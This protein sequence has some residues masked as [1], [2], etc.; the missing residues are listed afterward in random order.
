MD[1]N[2]ISRL[3]DSYSPINESTINNESSDITPLSLNNGVYTDK[4]L[5]D[6]FWNWHKILFHNQDKV[7]EMT[8]KANKVY[9]KMLNYTTDIGNRINKLSTSAKGAALADRSN[10]K[11][12]KIVYYTPTN[13]SYNPEDTTASV[14]NGKIFGVNNS[15]KFDSDKDISNS[16]ITL[17]HIR[18]TM[19]DITG[20]NDCLIRSHDN[21]P[22]M[23][24]DEIIN[25]MKRFNVTGTSS[26]S[27]SKTIEFVVDRAEYN[28]F[29]NIQIKTEK[30]YVYTVY[31]SVDGVYYNPLNS[32]KILTNELDL[33]FNLSN[34]RYIKISVHFSRHTLLNNGLYNYIWDVNHIFIAMK[35][36]K[37]ETVFQSN[38]IDINAAGEYIAIDT[39]DNYENKNVSINY[40]ISIDGGIFKTIKPLRA[41]SRSDYTIRSLI[42]INDFIDNNVGVMTKF[43]ESEGKHIYT[44]L[45]DKGMF[46]SNIIKFYNGSN[47]F[48]D[49]GDSISIT[50]IMTKDKKVN[51]NDTVFIGGVPFSGETLL[52]CGLVTID[53]PKNK[54]NILFDYSNVEIVSYSNGTFI[55]K[56]DNIESTVYDRDYESNMFVLIVNTF[57]YIL[58]N[59]ITD[60]IEMDTKEDGVQLKTSDS[61]SKL[62]VLARSKYSPVKSVKIRADMKSLDSYTKPEITRI[63][64]K[65]V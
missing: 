55:I 24:T 12:T 42:P 15:D 6:T 5:R 61:V 62:Y 23:K 57:D 27:G 31:T 22:I 26:L 56:K 1:L 64:F 44:N 19:S 10:S 33:S 25:I 46:E 60:E 43:T 8:E 63:I 65:V 51:F 18:C 11:Y 37:S 58:G 35:K 53:V 50:G 9:E 13:K 32:D 36:Y 52:R 45:I 30:P 48:V 3:F 21:T 47:P 4:N 49:N 39:C 16:K 7:Y 28:S 14:S 54:F 2:K 34:D 38:D 29:N 41:I 20:V 17:E 59:E 40:M